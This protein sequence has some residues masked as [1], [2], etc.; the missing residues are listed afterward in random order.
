MVLMW[1]SKGVMLICILLLVLCISGLYKVFEKTP[2]NRFSNDKS[3]VA[4][5]VLW[6]II[7]IFILAIKLIIG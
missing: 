7:L 2:D 5:G 6:E 4:F 1:I 3:W